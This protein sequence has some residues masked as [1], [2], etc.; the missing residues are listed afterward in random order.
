MSDLEKR[1]S[2]VERKMGLETAVSSKRF[3]VNDYQNRNNEIDLTELLSVLWTGKWFVLGVTFLFAVIGAL[4]SLSLPNKYTSK[5]VYAPVQNQSGVSGLASQYGGLAAIAG[6]NLGSGALSDIDQAVALVT[7]WPFLENVVE[8]NKMEPY[9]LAVSGWDR[10]TRQ[11]L[12]NSEVFDS[13]RRV[14]LD[15]GSEASLVPT[16]YTVYQELRRLLSVTHDANTGMVTVAVTHYSPEIAKQ[17]VGLLVGAIN[18][19]FQS[20]DVIEARRNIAYLEGK[21]SETS[22]MEMR[23]V[24]YG[25]IESQI[26]TLMLAEVSG[27]YILKE[28]IPPKVP[29]KKSKPA[30][31]LICVLF[32]VLG[33]FISC[34]YILIR[35]FLIA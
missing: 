22:V 17:W 11:L 2:Q 3:D 28:V 20:R 14:W 27:E 25:M 31:T 35:G 33:G 29:E 10:K 4:Y 12:W 15:S 8:N 16:S 24:F 23:T 32:I 5:G 26:K 7:S 9:I 21:V 30:K 18:E 19:H 34:M 13:K 1:L 6:I